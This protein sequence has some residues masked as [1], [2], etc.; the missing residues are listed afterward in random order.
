ML[1]INADQ[2]GLLQWN[3]GPCGTDQMCNGNAHLTFSANADGSI[4][5]T[6]QSINYTLWSGDPAP[7]DFQPSAEDPKVGDTFQL[8]HSGA[9]LLY[10]TWFGEISSLNAGNRYWCDS[11]ALSAGWSQCGA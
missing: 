5:G 8:Q 10:A 4:K 6:I 3:E 11:Y 7:A 1:T 9:H 2:T